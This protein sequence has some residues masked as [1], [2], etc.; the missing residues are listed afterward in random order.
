MENKANE[1]LEW[2]LDTAILFLKENKIDFRINHQ[3][4]KDYM[5]TCDFKPER[6]NLKVMQGIITEV[7]YG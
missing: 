1:V 7:T 2:H 5:I 4:L 3:D 6:A